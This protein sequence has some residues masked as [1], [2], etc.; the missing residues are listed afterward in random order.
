M[1]MFVQG[2]I[3]LGYKPEGKGQLEK[4]FKIAV[5]S[6]RSSDGKT[7]GSGSPKSSGPLLT[8]EGFKQFFRHLP[9]TNEDPGDEPDDENLMLSM[10]DR[11]RTRSVA[12][13][14]VK[15]KAYSQKPKAS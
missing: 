9:S 10:S 2:F 1:E 3:Q 14:P 4:M 12:M 6:K 8:A 5:K 13:I 11:L 7:E 15:F